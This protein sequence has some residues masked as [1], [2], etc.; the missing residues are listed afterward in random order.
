MYA[1]LLSQH[2]KAQAVERVKL[3][4][5][6]DKCYKNKE[7]YLGIC[8]DGMDQKKIELPHFL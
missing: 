5:H 1:N 3:A 6:R 8:I 4:K 2:R 7:R